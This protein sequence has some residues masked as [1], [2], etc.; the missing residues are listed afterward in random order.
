LEHGD[1]NVPFNYE[2][3]TELALWVIHQRYN[4]NLLEPSQRQ[5]LDKAGFIFLDEWK[6]NVMFERLCKYA[7]THN[8]CLV[9]AVYK[10]D[11][12][13]A[14]WVVEQRFAEHTMP[15]KQKEKL[16]MAGFVFDENWDNSSN[17]KASSTAAAKAAW[18]AMFQRLVNYKSQN[19]TC[20]VPTRYSNDP[21]LG[22]W[23]DKQRVREHSLS[24][25]R[26]QRLTNLG[27]VWSVYQTTWEKMLEALKLYKKQHGHC[28]VPRKYEANQQLGKWVDNQRY[29]LRQKRLAPERLAQLQSLGFE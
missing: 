13:L 1:C 16:Q 19:G 25:E 4:A 11:Q 3:D 28:R 18:E 24:K 22:R 26:K 20:Q 2:K 9:P 8:D 14:D 15:A 12:D 27:F 21:Q 10:D 23:V 6:W 29:M 5:K 7:V 17:T